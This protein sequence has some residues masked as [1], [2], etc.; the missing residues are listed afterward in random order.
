MTLNKISAVVAAYAASLEAAGSLDAAA[1]MTALAAAL[2]S[3]GKMDMRMLAK[4]LKA[5]S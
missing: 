4:V 5:R 3:K 2:K 1:K